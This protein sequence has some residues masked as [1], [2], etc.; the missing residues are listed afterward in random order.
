MYGIL[1]DKYIETLED[2]TKIAKTKRN[3]IVLQRD[4]GFEIQTRD[5]SKTL[6]SKPGKKP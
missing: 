4:G 3:R 1:D 2:G 5:G 6:Y